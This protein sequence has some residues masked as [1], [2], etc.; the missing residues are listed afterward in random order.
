MQSKSR[1]PHQ[2][3]PF[4][5]LHYFAFFFFAPRWMLQLAFPSSWDPDA[6]VWMRFITARMQHNGVTSAGPRP[7]EPKELPPT[8]NWQGYCGR[9]SSG[10]Q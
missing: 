1:G 9:G 10:C 7:V 2:R 4:V 3:L 6:H 8:G 5:F